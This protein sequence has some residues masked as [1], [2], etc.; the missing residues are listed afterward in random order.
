MDV[1][2]VFIRGFGLGG[3][4]LMVLEG[5]VADEK[6]GA[7]AVAVLDVTEVDARDAQDACGLGDRELVWGFGG[8][9]A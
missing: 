4:G 1:F 8:G 2:F 9:R 3:D 7:S 6:F 5:L